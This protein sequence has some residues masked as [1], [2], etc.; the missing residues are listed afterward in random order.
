MWSPLFPQVRRCGGGYGG[1]ITK[2]TPIAAATAAAAVVLGK[3][4]KIEMELLQVCLKIWNDF[5]LA[6]S[7]GVRLST[8]TYTHPYYTEHGNVG[9]SKA[10]PTSIPSRSQQGWHCDRRDGRN[11][12]LARMAKRLGWRNW[13]TKL[14]AVIHWQRLQHPELGPQGLPALMILERY[15]KSPLSFCNFHYFFEINKK[16]KKKK[17]TLLLGI[18]LLFWEL[19]CNFQGWACKTNTPSNTACRSPTFLPGTFLIEQVETCARDS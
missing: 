5:L 11:L 6:H 12:Q 1:K 13:W 10:T 15:S 17:K 18:W 9:L 3:P 14:S 16:K 19:S 7:P 2:N 8:K 4:V